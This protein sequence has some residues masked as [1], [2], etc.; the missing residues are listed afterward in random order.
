MIVVGDDA[1]LSIVS[2]I[3]GS[4]SDRTGRPD[5][6][7]ILI[8]QP[9]F[10]KGGAER[11]I[12]ALASRFLRN[13]HSVTLL[14]C[15]IEGS[16]WM[17]QVIREGLEVLVATPDGRTARPW[18]SMGYLGRLQSIGI[19]GSY[20]KRN[21]AALHDYDI[22]N[23][24]NWPS[25]L[26]ARSAGLLEIDSPPIVWT[27]NEPTEFWFSKNPLLRSPLHGFEKKAIKEL[28]CI[29]VLSTYM[30][31]LMAAR[32]G[33]RSRI[34]APGLDAGPRREEF[35]VE[36]R[37]QPDRLDIACYARRPFFPV[38]V[39]AKIKRVF[40]NS[41]LHLFGPRAELGYRH[42]RRKGL[43]AHVTVHDWISEAEMA[44]FMASMD[45]MI[46][47]HLAPFGLAAVE[48]L[49]AGVPVVSI[50]AGGPLDFIRDGVNG[51]L[52][53]DVSSKAFADVILSHMSA[54]K[55]ADMRLRCSKDAIQRFSWDK[56]ANQYLELFGELTD[57]LGRGE[58]L[59][60]SR[61]GRAAD[62]G[63]GPS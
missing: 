1:R 29:V 31:E 58:G 18:I 30:Q 12:A 20:L 17:T 51:Y 9:L 8:V 63:D 37:A 36:R 43:Q 53:S 14:S 59:V 15:V 33:V 2:D 10:L 22:I 27:C 42:A 16:D 23:L 49:A 6:A 41:M 62:S 32:Y 24:H 34:I 50:A 19:L 26:S 56:T 25:Y 5:T 21:L 7:R 44:E 13:G 28:S 47:H 45:V 35:I 40:P 46:F 52:V 57:G 3:R 60:S 38:E 48:A 55:S 4:R 54:M 39:L 11:Q 61:D